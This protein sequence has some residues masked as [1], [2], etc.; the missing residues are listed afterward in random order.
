M[1][2]TGRGLC[3]QYIHVG[4]FAIF[5]PDLGFHKSNII[6]FYFFYI[7]NWEKELI[8]RRILMILFINVPLEGRLDLITAKINKASV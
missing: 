6:F 2:E 4:V 1:E 3:P 7:I 5:S 8:V